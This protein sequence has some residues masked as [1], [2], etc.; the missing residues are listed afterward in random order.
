LAAL[1]LRRIFFLR[2]FQRW[3]PFFFQTLELLFM[4]R[5]NPLGEQAGGSRDPS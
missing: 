3:F 4:E 2:H 1:R 5:E